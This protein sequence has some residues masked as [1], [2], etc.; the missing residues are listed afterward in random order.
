MTKKHDDYRAWTNAEIQDDPD[1]FLAAQQRTQEWE[2]TEQQRQ[3][4]EEELRRFE[5]SFVMAGGEK[6]AAKAAY[7]S[8][9][10]QQALKSATQADHEARMLLRGKVWDK[11]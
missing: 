3:R 10:N 8:L 4:E 9:K 1:G 5:R 2:L 6:S 11:I 7:E